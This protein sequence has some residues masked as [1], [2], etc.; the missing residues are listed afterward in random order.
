L[1]TWPPHVSHLALSPPPAPTP[2]RAAPAA[3]H[4]AM[5]GEPSAVFPRGAG[6]VASRRGADCPHP[7]T[8]LCV[9]IGLAGCD[10]ERVFL[11]A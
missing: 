4:M 10:L 6:S 8:W 2:V 7:N 11:S 3:G 5:L 9:K 1:R